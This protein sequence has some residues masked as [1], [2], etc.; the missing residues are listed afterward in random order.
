MKRAVV[1]LPF[2]LVACKQQLDHERLVASIKDG[3][4]TKNLKLAALTCPSDRPVKAG[5]TFTCT[6]TTADNQPVS[7]DVTQKDDAGN[8]QWE[9]RGMILDAAMIKSD[10]V[11]QLGSGFSLDCPFTA[12]VTKIGDVT[13]CHVAKDGARGKLD[14]T[15]DDAQGNVSYKLAM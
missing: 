4:A 10:I 12:T 1:L 7:F 9:L 2:A 8:V 6:G 15:M 3:T 11:P 13:T 14:I 5:D